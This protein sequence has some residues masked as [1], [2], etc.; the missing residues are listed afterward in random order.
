MWCQPGT[1]SVSP[2]A[3]NKG[4]YPSCFTCPVDAVCL[5]GNLVQFRMG[6]WI[7]AD[8]GTMFTLVGCPSGYALINSVNGQF[9]HDVQRCSKCQS[10]EYVLDSSDSSFS[11]TPCPVGATCD[12]ATLHPLVAGSLWE[13]DM[14]R[15]MWVLKS[16]PPGY[17][18]ESLD[19]NGKFSFMNQHCEICSAGFFCD[20][21]NAAKVPCPQEQFSS[22]GSSE[23][24]NCTAASLV[25]VTVS[26]PLAAADF[27][28]DQQNKFVVAM[29]ATAGCPPASV[30][31]QNVYSARRAGAGSM[32]V[33]TKIATKD[34]GAASALVGSF[35]AA[36]LNSEL[37]KQGLPQGT[38]T[39]LGIASSSVAS[40]DSERLLST[41]LGSVLGGVT[42]LSLVIIC[43]LWR[44]HKRAYSEEERILN[45]S[46]VELRSRLRIR[47]EDGHLLSIER[48]PVWKRQKDAV[49]YTIIPKSQMDAAA[50][51]ALLHDFDIYL[52]DAF[53]LGLECEARAASPQRSHF[54]RGP[55]RGHDRRTV[56]Y[57]ALCEWLLDLSA[58]LLK[59]HCLVHSSDA[60]SCPLRFE[61]R[62]PYFMS[63]V[64]RARIWTDHQN[65]LFQRLKLIAGSYMAEIERSCAQC[66]DLMCE[67]PEADALIN[68]CYSPKHHD[69]APP[70]TRQDDPQVD[71]P[72]P[73]PL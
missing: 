66:F 25:L 10:N 49:A 3:T 12:G 6:S 11:C 5:G 2:L 17:V 38:L 32:V 35:D 61:E 44:R 40:S 69:W 27:T 59:P 7:I 53:C 62:F 39:S 42:L 23:K 9:N 65:L 18:L 60:D 24:G 26:L 64:I 72:I 28:K 73:Y 56:Q 57:A 30:V 55:G 1:Y 13:A 54:S 20:G 19:S 58:M 8:D 4:I 41:T 68:Y 47:R 50:R 36:K 15:G 34:R 21:G 70:I 31:I 37:A 71:G 33:D 52:F 63:K 16:C 51:L 45:R 43:A 46:I 67:L 29:A 14:T 48:P 22:P